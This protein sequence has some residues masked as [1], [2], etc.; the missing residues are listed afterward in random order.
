MKFKQAI[1]FGILNF[2]EFESSFSS[3]KYR[4]NG[5][6]EVLLG[7]FIKIFFEVIVENINKY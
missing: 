2:V 5:G 3:W 7:T 4:L 6:Y 1:H